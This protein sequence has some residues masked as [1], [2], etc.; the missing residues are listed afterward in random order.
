MREWEREGKAICAVNFALEREALDILRRY[1]S[2]PRG[3]GRFLARLLYE[4][5]AR[6]QERQRLREHLA[7]AVG[8]EVPA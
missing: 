3:Y 1:S 5:E 4:E 8:D 6:R 7:A 2:S